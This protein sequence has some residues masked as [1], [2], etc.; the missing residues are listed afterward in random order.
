MQGIAGVQPLAKGLEGVAYVQDTVAK[1]PVVR[2]ASFAVTPIAV[3]I[4]SYYAS[5][6]LEPRVMDLLDKSGVDRIPLLNKILVYPY[7]TTG[8]VVGLSLGA[9]AKYKLLNK[10]AASIVAA[11]AA[12]IGIALDLSLRSF[13]KAAT[14]V[15]SQE[16]AQ[17]DAVAS[18]AAAQA[19]ESIDPAAA[20]AIAANGVNGANGGNGMGAVALGAIGYGDGG[21]YTLGANTQA[22]GGLGEYGAIASEYSDASPADAHHSNHFMLPDE[23]SAAKAGPSFYIKKFGHSPQRKSGQRTMISRHAG[24]AGHRYGWLIKMFGFQNF[25]KLASLP[26]HQRAAVLEQLKQQAVGTIPQLVS[27]YQQEN[28]SLETASI[29]IQGAT[30]GA[31]GAEGL[32]YGALMYAGSNY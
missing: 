25:Q 16:I 2:W 31:G 26:P 9:L 32:G 24:R 1:V 11:S 3:G 5:K 30:N 8:V 4:V 22:L 17:A 21:A 18:V 14:D 12:S 28:A 27:Q 19:I 6:M 15:A 10:Q 20:A 13:A 7:T 23:V 29:P